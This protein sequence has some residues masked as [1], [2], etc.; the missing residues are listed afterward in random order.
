MRAAGHAPS[1]ITGSRD[2]AME[3]RLRVQ[4]EFENGITKV[5]ICT[6]LMTR[7]IDVP[8]MKLVIN[9][10]LPFEYTGGGPG[11]RQP[12]FATFQHRSGRVGRFGQVG[13]VVNLIASDGDADALGQLAQHFALPLR[14]LPAQSPEDASVAV[15]DA[16]ARPPAAPARG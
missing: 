13:A 3:E 2:V 7:G 15:E 9:F 16:M 8:G 6:D 5:L 1:V 10:D 11:P 4:E 12:D 14:S